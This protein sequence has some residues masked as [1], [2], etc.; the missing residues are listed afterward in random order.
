M[1]I[2][3]RYPAGIAL[4]LSALAVLGFGFAVAYRGALHYGELQKQ[5]QREYEWHYGPRD[6]PYPTGQGM[7]SPTVDPVLR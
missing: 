1:N 2:I 4:G 6:W 3:R 5:H 7:A